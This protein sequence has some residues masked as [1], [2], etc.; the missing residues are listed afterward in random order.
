LLM[1]MEA[2]L[3]PRGEDSMLRRRI[4]LYLVRGNGLNRHSPDG[5]D[6]S[7]ILAPIG[8]LGKLDPS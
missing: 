6:P 7:P 5:A 8:S 4:I 1:A 2:D 3:R